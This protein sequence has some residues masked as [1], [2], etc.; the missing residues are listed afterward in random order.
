VSAKE[1]KPE[2]RAISEGRMSEAHFGAV[3][4]PVYRASTILFPDMAALEA[5]TQ[6]YS[7]WPPRHADFAQLGRSHLHPWKAAPA[8]CWCRPAQRLRHSP[9]CRCAARAITC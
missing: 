5:R 6:E 1:E 2:T 8:P 9:S 3:N 4:T 7:L